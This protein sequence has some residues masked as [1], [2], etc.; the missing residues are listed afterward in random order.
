ML[1]TQKFHSLNEIDP[2]FVTSLEQLTHEEWPDFNAWKL[3]EQQCPVDDTFIYWLFFGP[4]QNAPIG[5]TQVCLRKLNPE[6]SNPWWKKIGGVFGVKPVDHRM[7]IWSLGSS[8]DGPAIFDSR[9]GRSGREKFWQLQKEVEVRAE[10]MAESIVL[11][12][13]WGTPKPGWAEVPYENRQTWQALRP[14]EKRHKLYQDYL[15]T[16]PAEPRATIQGIWKNLHAAHVK[17]GDFPTIA[18]RDDLQAECPGADLAVFSDKPGGLLTFQKDQRLLGAVHYQKGQQGTWFFEPIPLETHGE[19][20]VG[21]QLY[22]QYALLK[23]HETTEA[24]KLVIVK[25]N[26]P[27]RLNSPAEEEFFTSQGFVT[28]TLEEVCWARATDVL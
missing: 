26:R 17:L 15:G 3:A 9:F 18:S 5:V 24:R 1:L 21:D 10:I 4:T 19:E 22:V 7:A 11:P 28:R 8:S 20:V 16:L 12:Q 27:L 14:Y 25:H 13:G 6:K 23:W 2:E